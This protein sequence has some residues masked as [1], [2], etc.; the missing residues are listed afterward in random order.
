MESQLSTAK[1]FGG[2]I[3]NGEEYECDYD[4]CK[5]EV[6]SEGEIRYFPDL[7]RV[8]KEEPTTKEPEQ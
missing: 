1:Y 8:K 2:C 5:T 4:N 7:V 3:I 6:N